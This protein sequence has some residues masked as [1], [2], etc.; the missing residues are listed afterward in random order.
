MR[1]LKRKR[2]KKKS[3]VIWG[4]DTCL[5]NVD[6][7]WSDWIKLAITKT[8]QEWTGEACLLSQLKVKFFSH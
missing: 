7:G 5:R 2:K 1:V 8:V 4:T 6:K 3:S